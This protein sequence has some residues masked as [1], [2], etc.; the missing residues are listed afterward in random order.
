MTALVIQPAEHGGYLV[1]EPWRKDTITTPLYA[2]RLSE[3]FDYILRHF[4][5]ADAVCHDSLI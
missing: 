4:K 3:C 1:Y 5:D 2:G